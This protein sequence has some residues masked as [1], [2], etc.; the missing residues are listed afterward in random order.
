[1]YKNKKQQKE[2]TKKK[3]K[4]GGKIKV[5]ERKKHLKDNLQNKR[6]IT[7]IALVITI[8]VLLI[9][10][11]VSLSMISA[12][13]GIL[14]KA[15][16]AKEKNELNAALATLPE[17]EEKV[18]RSRFGLDDGKARTLE[19]VGKQFNVTR[20]RIRQIETKALRKLSKNPNNFRNLKDLLDERK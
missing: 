11:G 10:A 8:I 9:L 12:E 5:R 2:K 7:L 6:G 17:K 14:S 18:L 16:E 1:M 19:D 15:T 3:T 20:E 4:E 13:N